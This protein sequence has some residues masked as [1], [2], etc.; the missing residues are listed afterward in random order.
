MPTITVRLTD[1]DLRILKKVAQ[2]KDTSQSDLVRDYIHAGVAGD[3]SQDLL[4][5]RVEKALRERREQLQSLV[6][7]LKQ[8]HTAVPET[9]V[10]TAE[11]ETDE[12]DV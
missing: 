1:D 2:L 4:Q 8:V 11:P 3:T 12:S 7:D 6:E 9:Q 5:E 10:R